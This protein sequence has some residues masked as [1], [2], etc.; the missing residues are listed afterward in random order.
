[1][2]SNIACNSGISLAFVVSATMMERWGGGNHGQRSHYNMSVCNN[3]YKVRSGSHFPDWVWLHIGYGSTFNNQTTSQ[4]ITRW[5]A[6]TEMS[7]YL[8]LIPQCQISMST[9][10]QL[11]LYFKSQKNTS[12]QTV[13]MGLSKDMCVCVCVCVCVCACEFTFL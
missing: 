5:C 3:G 2:K 7:L 6:S 9:W 13:I 12:I 4:E 8:T 10:R 11:L 1:M